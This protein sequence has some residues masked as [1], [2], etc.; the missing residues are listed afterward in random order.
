MTEPQTRSGQLTH[1]LKC[2][3]IKMKPK[4]AS[5]QLMTWPN[6][7]LEHFVGII[8]FTRILIIQLRERLEN[9]NVIDYGNIQYI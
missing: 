9:T 1:R 3:Q 6:T 4:T 5:G 8:I 2:G 7:W